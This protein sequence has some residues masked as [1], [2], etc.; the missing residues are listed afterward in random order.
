MWHGR[1][2]GPMGLQYVRPC[3]SRTLQSCLGAD[4]CFKYCGS[5]YS[6]YLDLLDPLTAPVTQ[7]VKLD[8]VLSL[9]LPLLTILLFCFLVPPRYEGLHFTSQGWTLGEY[10]R[11]EP[12][13]S[14]INIG[15]V[16]QQFYQ[17]LLQH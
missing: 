7:V 13:D 8:Q 3:D 12:S 4:C 10:P 6:S 1:T 14:F 9:L 16:Y 2:V 5:S 17:C 11:Y 15:T